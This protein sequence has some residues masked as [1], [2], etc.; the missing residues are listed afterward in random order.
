M[1]VETRGPASVAEHSFDHRNPDFASLRRIEYARLD[2]AGHAYLD[3]TGAGL[4]AASQIEAHRERLLGDVL[5]NPHSEN[6]AALAST[7][8]MERARLRVLEFLRADP[9]V[10]DVVFTPNA[11]GALRLVGESFPFAPGSRYVLTRDNHNS[12]NGIRSFAARAG[13]VVHYVPLD[14]ELR[15][16]SPGSW[17]RKLPPNRPHLFAFPAQSNF[18]GVR[19]PLEWV[20]LARSQGVH[21]LL[22][23]A[24]FVPTSP[25]RLDQVEPDFVVLSFY[26]MFGFPTGI[27]ALVGRRQALAILERPWFA[28]G[29]V[30]WVSTQHGTHALRAAAEAFEDG[31]SHFLAF[32]AVCDGLDLLD[33]LGM[34]RIRTRIGAL[35]SKLLAALTTLRHPDGRRLL[36]IYGPPDSGD[37]GGTIAFNVVD[38]TGRHVPYPHVVA[39]AA[40]DR[41]SLRGGCFCNPGCAETALRMPA[42]RTRACRETLGRDFTLEGFAACIAGPVGAVRASLGIPTVARDIDRLIRVLDRYRGYIHR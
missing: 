34:E 8:R 33:S 29:T 6:P 15:A 18:S 38:A 11:S 5:G 26:K 30:E 31:T 7:A 19:H 1:Q 42:D 39:E 13:A 17:L 22:D 25:L 36:E 10:Y 35:T 32:D 23:A 37:R 4:Y 9:V 20:E 2:Q 40:R 12:V 21:V 28:G 16:D 41:V 24:A 3:Y 14:A 27:G